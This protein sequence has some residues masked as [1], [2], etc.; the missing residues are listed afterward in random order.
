MRY[1]RHEQYPIIL[2]NYIVCILNMSP[3]RRR[4][5]KA[6]CA[7]HKDTIRLNYQASKVQMLRKAG[8]G[9]LWEP[10]TLRRLIQRVPQT[11]LLCVSL[12]H[13]LQLLF[14]QDVFLCLKPSRE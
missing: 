1:C 13:L 10:L 6:L 8:H 4:L 7:K 12:S 2:R 14:Q 9:W 5:W 3:G 11:E